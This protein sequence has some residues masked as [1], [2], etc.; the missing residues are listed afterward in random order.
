MICSRVFLREKGFRHCRVRD[1]E[2]YLALSTDWLIGLRLG[3]GFSYISS[4]TQQVTLNES[5]HQSS[6]SKGRR[7][8]MEKQNRETR[9]SGGCKQK[10]C[11]N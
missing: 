2:D 6:A 11:W 7:E 10:K 5:G 8:C 3:L 9:L 4:R 1:E